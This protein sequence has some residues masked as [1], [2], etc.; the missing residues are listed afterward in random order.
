MGEI[1][2]GAPLAE[3]MALFVGS[4]RTRLG[5]DRPGGGISR[6]GHRG[7]FPSSPLDLRFVPPSPSPFLS[8]PHSQLALIRLTMSPHLSP[9]SPPKSS[10]LEKCPGAPDLRALACP[11]FPPFE[12]YVD[13]SVE[14]PSMF[15][16]TS[17]ENSLD[18]PSPT[19]E[20]TSRVFQVLTT[21]LKR[22][23]PLRGRPSSKSTKE[24][25]W[26][27][28]VKQG[29]ATPELLLHPHLPS[30]SDLRLFLH[31][32]DPESSPSLVSHDSAAFEDAADDLPPPSLLN[33]FSSLS[34]RDNRTSHSRSRSHSRN[35][36]TRDGKLLTEPEIPKDDDVFFRH[37]LQTSPQTSP[38][39]RTVG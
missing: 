23:G 35:P 22:P 12:L 4:C 39:E 25:D 17:A 18:L 13:D 19:L 20:S 8:P 26:I 21:S 28:L 37:D 34:K 1:L 3:R 6:T 36:A 29:G 9:S 11:V 30:D 33:T 2:G 15:E 16:G 10:H 32:L 24:C 7:S 38:S 31:G 5:C 27:D 14:I